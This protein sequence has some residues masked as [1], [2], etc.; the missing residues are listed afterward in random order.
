MG[1]VAP[2]QMGEWLTAMCSSLNADELT[3]I[4]GGMKQ[5]AP[6][7]VMEWAYGIAEQ[8]MRAGAWEKVR[9]RIS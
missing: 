5:G 4:L 2:E 8:A 3:T 7:Q 9:A 6:P 1:S